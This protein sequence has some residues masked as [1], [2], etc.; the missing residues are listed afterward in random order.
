MGSTRLRSSRCFMGSTRP[1]VHGPLRTSSE[2]MVDHF[3]CSVPPV[4]SMVDTSGEHLLF[5]LGVNPESC[6]HQLAD[7]MEEGGPVLTSDRDRAQ[8]ILGGPPLDPTW[9]GGPGK[10]CDSETTLFHV[11]SHSPSQTFPP[12]PSVPRNFPPCPRISPAC[13][14][15]VGFGGT[16]SSSQTKTKKDNCSAFLFCV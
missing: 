16:V 8:S 9:T 10:V 13:L 11:S 15:Q 3:E 4:S 2:H 7:A 5:A 14:F 12:V 6:P 1:D